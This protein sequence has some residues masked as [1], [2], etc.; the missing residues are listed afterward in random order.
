MSGLVPGLQNQLVRF[1]SATHLDNPNFLSRKVGII[2]ID[3]Y[4]PTLYEN[5]A[6]FARIPFISHSTTSRRTIA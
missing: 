6:L 4:I 5:I 1:D 3:K 2:F